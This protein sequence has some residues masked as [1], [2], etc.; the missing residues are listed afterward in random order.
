MSFF[1]GQNAYTIGHREL[2]HIA[3][4]NDFDLVRKEEA[5]AGFAAGK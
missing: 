3:R 5:P 2:R 4:L 1:P